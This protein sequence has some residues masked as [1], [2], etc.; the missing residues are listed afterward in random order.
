MESVS[1]RKKLLTV[2]QL[3][4]EYL[5]ECRTK[6]TYDIIE[7]YDASSLGE[8]IDYYY[9]F[10]KRSMMCNQLMKVDTSQ[11]N[12]EDLAEV[13]FLLAITAAAE[14]ANLE[15]FDDTKKTSEE[16]RLFLMGEILVALRDHSFL[17]LFT[18]DDYKRFWKMEGFEYLAK[19]K[20][21]NVPPSISAMMFEYAFKHR[22]NIVG[23][24]SDE[25]CPFFGQSKFGN[26][27][28]LKGITKYLEKAVPSTTNILVKDVE[29]Q[30]FKPY[31]PPQPL[32]KDVIY[33][34]VKRGEIIFPDF[35]E[36]GRVFWP[37]IDQN[38]S[39]ATNTSTNSGYSNASDYG[40][41][42]LGKLA[43]VIDHILYYLV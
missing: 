27:V 10:P 13:N 1:T 43:L 33:P 15:V 11:N 38:A 28:N 19:N 39:I 34:I 5:H 17:T 30:E 16:I 22:Q 35:D 42:N 24:K 6:F 37:Q 9:Y 40:I 25:N 18:Y 32:Q 8:V 41:E 2:N 4:C 12:S 31:V 7:K 26:L 3:V 14:V 36:S 21:F 23:N 20:T 29:A